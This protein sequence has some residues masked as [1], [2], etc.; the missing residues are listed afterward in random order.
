MITVNFAPGDIVEV[1]QQIQEGDKTRTQMFAGVVLQIRGRD[2]N[3]SFSVQKMVG[4]VAVERIWQV[5]SPFLVQVKVK[6]NV[7]KGRKVRKAH[8]TYLRKTK[9]NN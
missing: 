6:G 5:N 3:K 8:L 7:N 4:D 9:R 1:Y 2:E